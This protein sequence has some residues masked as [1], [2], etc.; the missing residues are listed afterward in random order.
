MHSCD[1]IDAPT[2]GNPIGLWNLPIDSIT[3]PDGCAIAIPNPESRTVLAG[4][5]DRDI[6]TQHQRSAAG[7]RRICD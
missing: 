6:Q 2:I 4:V 5:S 1:H 7:G 3:N